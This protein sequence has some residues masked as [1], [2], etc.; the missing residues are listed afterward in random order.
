MESYEIIK[1]IFP[2]LR[3]VRLKINEKIKRIMKMCDDKNILND[4]HK[5]KIYK[6]D[7]KSL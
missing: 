4:E 1:E 5:K 7:I 2:T 6:E 3:I